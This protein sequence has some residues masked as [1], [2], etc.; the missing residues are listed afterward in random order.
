VSPR[1]GGDVSNS[2]E[3][4]VMGSGEYTGLRH[5]D[6]T[7][8]DVALRYLRENTWKALLLVY[9]T[10]T[11]VARLHDVWFYRRFRVNI[12]YYSDPED[13]LLAAMKNPIAVL[14]FLI[15]I[16][17]LLIA[18]WVASRRQVARMKRSSSSNTPTRRLVAASVLVVMTAATMTAIHAERRAKAVQAGIG[19][20]VSFTR[21]DG[22]TYDEK[23]LL[24][25]STGQ[26]FFLY[27]V[28]R[29]VAEIVPVENTALMSVD[30]GRSNGA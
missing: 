12:F 1:P 21:N 28:K 17:I 4:A 30:L 11:V 26:F 3:F 23:P 22:V 8:L 13:F 18:S 9:L 7:A 29:R 2:S 25:G 5:R 10:V 15:P 20:H 14:Y 19:R 27:Y 24:L 6:K 16:A